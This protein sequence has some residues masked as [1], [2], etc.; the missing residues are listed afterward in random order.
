LIIEQGEGSRQPVRGLL[1]IAEDG[2]R[3]R[4]DGYQAS[5]RQCRG[6]RSLFYLGDGFLKR[7]R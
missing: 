7:A 2:Y 1:L 5:E 6:H 4:D 3:V